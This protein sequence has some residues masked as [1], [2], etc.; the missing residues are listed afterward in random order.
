MVGACW[1]FVLCS[2]SVC[3]RVYASCELI[4]SVVVTRSVVTA[5]ELES[6]VF[7]F[8]IVC[9]RLQARFYI[10]CE[11]LSLFEIWRVVCFVPTLCARV[12]THCSKCC[13]CEIWLGL[14]EVLP[15]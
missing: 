4:W 10:S 9:T 15:L 7:C 6:G 14:F 13:R 1:S 5:R 12:C 2:C 3:M 8:R 11:V